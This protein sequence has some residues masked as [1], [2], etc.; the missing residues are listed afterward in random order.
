MSEAHDEPEDEA[1]V[2]EAELEALEALFARDRAARDPGAHFFAS[3][4]AEIM[5]GL[6]ARDALPGGQAAP[7]PSEG[8]WGRWRGLFLARPSVAWGA[9]MAAGLAAVALWPGEA[10]PAPEAPAVTASAL[11]EAE[12]ARL[13]E[14]AAGMKIDLLEEEGGWADLAQVDVAEPGLE[15]VLQGMSD[16]ELELLE[17]AW[18]RAL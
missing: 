8:W 1:G 6:P 5:A 9:V 17:D 12:L 4:Q 18:D 11:D 14:L 13:R 16:E 10:P 15:D 2:S 3:M 7:T